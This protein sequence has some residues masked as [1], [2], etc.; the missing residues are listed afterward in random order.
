MYFI[1]F[2]RFDNICV[3]Y[4]EKKSINIFAGRKEI[5][6]G[7]RSCRARSYAVGSK[8]D[9]AYSV[10]WREN[11]KVQTNIIKLYIYLFLLLEIICKSFF[12]RIILQPIKL[13][14]AVLIVFGYRVADRRH[15]S[16]I[17]YSD[18]IPDYGLGH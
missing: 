15:H 4:T 13:F 2:Y 16:P 11:Q 5:S 6:E 17:L 18:S 10:V 14:R 9:R 7:T 3:F 1:T 8:H 12:I